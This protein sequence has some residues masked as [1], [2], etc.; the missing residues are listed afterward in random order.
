MRVRTLTLDGTI[1][2]HLPNT[3]DEIHGYECGCK[4][5]YEMP[6]SMQLLVQLLAKGW[7]YESDLHYLLVTQF[8]LRSMKAKIRSVLLLEPPLV[9]GANKSDTV[10]FPTQV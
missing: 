9:M 2:Y 1:R 4:A 3:A 10:G 7:S 5:F 8:A 6:T